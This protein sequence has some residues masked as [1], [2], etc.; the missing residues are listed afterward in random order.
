MTFAD[1]STVKIT[2]AGGANYGCFLVQSVRLADG[3]L[4]SIIKVQDEGDIEVTVNSGSKFEVVTP[5]AIV[6]VRGTHFTVTTTDLGDL[7]F[8][9]DVNLDEGTVVL[10]DRD[11]GKTVTLTEG[12]IE[13]GTV[14]QQMHSHAHWHADGTYHDHSHGSVSNAHHGNPTA[15]KKAAAASTDAD[16]DNDGDG[17]SENEG[18]CDDTNVAVYPGATD[19]PDNGIDENCDGQDATDDDSND[20][21]D[22]GDG[23]TENEGD[24]DDNDINV[25]PGAT[26][27]A[28]NGID[29][30]CDPETSDS[31]AD[32]TLIDLINQQPPLASSDLKNALIAASPLSESI[33][34]EMINRDIMGGK[35]HKDV[36]IA[37]SPLSENVL[38]T[39]INAVQIIEDGGSHD[40][41]HHTIMGGK[42]FMKVLIANSPL[43][44]SILDQVVAGTPQMSD[45]DRQ[46]ILDAQ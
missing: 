33:L 2:T 44:Q 16:E 12:G 38:N 11:T 13:D 19:I 6:G 34:V 37:N 46:A 24:C 14:D 30:D 10:M 28:G 18:D 15:A 22:D 31:S 43:P 21:D 9:T 27:I 7:G 45:G 35:D 17:F 26:E 36:L 42:D 20:V 1:G 8:T 39:A 3:T 32:Q 25:N 23:Y 29:D 40:G 5:S 4:Y 41:H